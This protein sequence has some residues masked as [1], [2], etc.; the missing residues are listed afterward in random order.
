MRSMYIST[1]V[2]HCI[3]VIL[4]A[5][6]MAMAQTPIASIGFNSAEDSPYFTVGDLN[7]QG[8][9]T[10]GWAGPWVANAGACLVVAGGSPAS[11]TCALDSPGDPDQ[12]LAMIGAV[13][14]SYKAERPMTLWSG[15]FV[16]EFDAK[17]TGLPI[18]TQQIQFEGTSSSLRPLNIKW[19]ADG[20]F[21]LNDTVMLNYNTGSA[22]FQSMVGNW[23]T[24]KIVCRWEAKTFDLYWTNKT[25]GCLTKVGTK[26]GFK[27]AAFLTTMTV[28]QM[29]IGV[30]KVNVPTNG[31]EI[32]RIKLVTAPP[33]GPC[34][35]S[36]A[37]NSGA[38]RVTVVTGSS[39][40]P[41]TYTLHNGGNVSH[42]YDVDEMAAVAHS[43]SGLFNT[44]VDASGVPLSDQTLDPHYALT[45]NPDSAGSA[46][47]TSKDDG[48][49]IPPWIASNSTSRWLTVRPDDD[50][51]VGAPGSYV[52]RTTFTAPGGDTTIYGLLAADDNLTDVLVNG[53]STGIRNVNLFQSWTMFNLNLGATD[54]TLDFNL[55]NGGSA[56]N[57]TGLRV[58]FFG[59]SPQDQTWLSVAPAN[60]ITVASQTSSSVTAMIDT[61]GL[62]VGVYSAYLRFKNLDD[63]DP[64]NNSFEDP[65]VRRIEM[66]LTNWEVTPASALQDVSASANCP[67]HIPDTV[68][69][70]V[71]NLASAGDVT[72]TVAKM[73][74]CDWLT[75][76]KTGPV[77]VG[78]GLGDVLTGTIDPTGL[79]VGTYT[80]SLV[81][82]NVGTALP[83]E[84]RT[85]TLHILGTLWEYNG[86]VSPEDLDSAGPGRN[87]I[88]HSESPM[89]ISQGQVEND[90]LATDG[91]VWRLTDSA[92]AKTK[93]RSQPNTWVSGQLGATLVA[94]VRVH[95]IGPDTSQ[96]LALG[97]WDDV[98]GDTAEVFYSGNEGAGSGTLKE[99]KRN[100]SVVVTG[101]D[102]FH[103]IRVTVQGTIIL[104]RVI[105]VYFDENAT[106]AI[107]ITSASNN[108]TGIDGFVFGAGNTPGQIDMAFDWLT[109]T[110]VGAF[111]PGEE[112]ECLGRSLVIDACPT[113]FA[114]SNEDGDVDMDDFAVLQRC[115]NIGGGAYDAETC[116]C[117]DRGHDNDVDEYDLTSFLDCATGPAV[118]WTQELAPFCQP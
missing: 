71:N 60:P 14:S 27:D 1:K 41:I 93:F 92:T 82:T 88:I 62:P 65:F 18:A 11:A 113:P 20:S 44:G 45:S 105:N 4:V 110:D 17:Y 37:I 47:Y 29:E 66:T 89:P 81:F 72:Y 83:K 59:L 21:K 73:D 40:S 12:R 75:L 94:R 61:T 58:E 109:A 38:E 46:T 53:V 8:G 115:I 78:P 63:C 25:D 97:I 91:K 52:Y 80:C 76:D 67:G 51:S 36:I 9:V 87:F 90:P 32:D 48:F 54:N 114:D 106:P 95:S 42:D 43:I 101:D 30:P 6:T 2:V 39:P 16:F 10:N 102:Q 3:V 34:N 7:G 49:P 22:I 15:D 118:L 50:D 99:M 107:S 100:Q 103:V 117:F 79:A 26:I 68:Q 77:V 86:D 74:V 104:D 111:A 28:Q 85:V 96:G 84:V 56:A 70:T 69:F 55:T 98:T 35:T 19:E 112:F 31:L 33:P 108:T 24:V 23:V 57:S 64:P 13:T 116:Q 5:G